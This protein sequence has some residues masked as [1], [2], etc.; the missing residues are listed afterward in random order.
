MVCLIIFAAC[1]LLTFATDSF[2]YATIALPCWIIAAVI[3]AR[4]SR[5]HTRDVESF[6]SLNEQKLGHIFSCEPSRGL[7]NLD[8]DQLDLYDCVTFTYLGRVPKSDLLLILDS[9][10]DMPDLLPNGDNDIPFSIDDYEAIPV[11]HN[12]QFSDSFT[13]VL[14]DGIAFAMDSHCQDRWL[15][16]CGRQTC[17][18]G[19]CVSLQAVCIHATT[20]PSGRA[21]NLGI[22]SAEHPDEPTQFLPLPGARCKH[23]NLYKSSY[24]YPSQMLDASG[25]SSVFR[26]STTAVRSAGESRRKFLTAGR[27]SPPWYKMAST[28]V[29]ARPSCR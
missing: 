27:A 19:K 13:R 9:Y 28:S 20:V 15:T 10:A 4:Q 29:L 24:V 2:W 21:M 26:N 6:R 5:R 3:E 23:A 8:D 11:I 17:T 16:S 25:G 1:V 22:L 7:R 14:P 18:H 12:Q